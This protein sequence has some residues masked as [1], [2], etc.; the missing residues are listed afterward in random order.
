MRTEAQAGGQGIGCDHQEL[1]CFSDSSGSGLFPGR[2]LKSLKDC[3][4][5]AVEMGE[6]EAYEPEPSVS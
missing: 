1:S 3:L 2:N 4:R 6:E 5:K